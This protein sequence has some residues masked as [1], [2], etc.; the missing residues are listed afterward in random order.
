[1]PT[2]VEIAKKTGR[3]VAFFFGEE[4]VRAVLGVMDPAGRIDMR[5]PG[6]GHGLIHL[7]EACP[8]YFDAGDRLVIDPSGH[9][10]GVWLV[11]RT[12]ATED[13]WLAWSR[14]HAGLPLLVRPSE[15]AIIYS[16]AVHDVVGAV[17]DVVKAPPA[18]PSA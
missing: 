7:P 17:V 8:P 14:E 16:E 3:A 1:M 18:G 9:R 6:T 11:I 10:F 2:I 4:G 13:V 12:R 15:E 5:T